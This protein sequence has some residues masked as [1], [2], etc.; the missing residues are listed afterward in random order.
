M[1]NYL[2][3][4]LNEKIIELHVAKA[5]DNR[6]F[7]EQRYIEIKES[8]KKAEDSLQSFQERTG[9]FEA[10]EQT[11]ATLDGF[12]KLESDLAVKQIEFSIF[13][14]IYGENSPTTTNAKIS[15]KEYQNLIDRLK[16]G[17]DKSNVLIGINSLPE[18]VMS[19][20]K[21]FRDVKIYNQ[22]LEFIIPLYEQSKF[23]EQKTI[24]IVQIIDYAVP[25]EK[26]SYPPRTLMAIIVSC[27]VL[28]GTLFLIIV[29]ELLSGATNPK[30][31][32]IK[33][34]LFNFRNK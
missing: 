6:S 33:K 10:T 7:L 17:H 25:P 26:K 19:Y 9:I 34:E 8:V 11:K 21:Y 13:D 16:S 30:I 20:Y 31:V 29:K 3:T 22:M 24:P 32:F 1:A 27:I 18:K 12:A 28:C 14:K 5:R 2:V 4:Y 23:D 15:V